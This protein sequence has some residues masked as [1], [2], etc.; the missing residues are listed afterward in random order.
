MAS[1]LSDEETI[2]DETKKRR[3]FWGWRVVTAA[4]AV[5]AGIALVALYGPRLLQERVPRDASKMIAFNDD[6]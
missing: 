4:C 3:R 2:I 1:D 5:G 6:G